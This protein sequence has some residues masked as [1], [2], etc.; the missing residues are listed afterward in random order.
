LLPFLI[1]VLSK[2]TGGKGN[3]SA[4]KIEDYRRGKGCTKAKVFPAVLDKII[5]KRIDPQ[6]QLQ[7]EVIIPRNGAN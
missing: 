1:K 5:N 2:V 4:K 7:R 3:F 6:P